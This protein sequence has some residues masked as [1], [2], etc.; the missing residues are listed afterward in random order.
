MNPADDPHDLNRFV[1]AQEH[2]YT[3][4]LAELRAGQ[5]RTH[6]MWYIFPQMVGLGFSS[7]AKFYAIQSE[8]E[9]RAYLAH[10]L[11]GPR[12]IECCQ[13]LLSLENRSALAI[14]G[15]TDEL[16]LCSCMTLFAAV[17]PPGSDS[18]FDRVLSSYF[19]GQRDEKTLQILRTQSVPS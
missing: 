4:A 19:H 13:A 5:K 8:A 9:A 17:S 18:V 14:F 11:L 6:W 10:P 1:A 3:R 12:L 15:S 16:K 2:D 7:T